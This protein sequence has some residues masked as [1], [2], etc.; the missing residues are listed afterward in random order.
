MKSFLLL[1]LIAV[2]GCSTM[3]EKDYR[4]KSGREKK[5]FE[6]A[7]RGI[8]L[9]YVYD[10]FDSFRRVELAWAGI[11]QDVQFKEMDRTIQVAFE[12]DHRKFDWSSHGGI[13]PFHLSE[14]GDGVFTAGWVVQKPARISYLKALAKPGYMILVYGKPYQVNDGIIQLKATAVRP[15]SPGNFEIIPV[16]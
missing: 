8:P 10:D 14:Q 1:S 9:S 11:I 13:K 15:V 7:S 4:P 2:T 16:Q 5:A 3:K 12:V 6:T